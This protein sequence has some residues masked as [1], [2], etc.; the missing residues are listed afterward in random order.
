M[1]MMVCAPE[2]SRELAPVLLGGTSEKTHVLISA[3]PRYESGIQ[4]N[5]SDGTYH[6]NMQG[7]DGLDVHESDVSGS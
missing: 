7:G 3:Y 5:G 1:S 4:K 2:L 6:Q